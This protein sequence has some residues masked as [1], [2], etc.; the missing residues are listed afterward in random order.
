MADPGTARGTGWRQAAGFPPGGAMPEVGVIG[1]IN[2]DTIHHPDGRS[3]ESLGGILFTACALAHLGQGRLRTRPFARLPREIEPRVEALLGACPEVS[4]GGLRRLDGP[5]FRCEIR[6]DRAGRKSERLRGD[7]PPLAPPDLPCSNSSLDALLVNFITGFELEPDTLRG[8][9]RIVD[10]PILMDVHSLT[11]A[12]DAEG[13]RHPRPPPSWPLWAS[14]A[15][16]VQMNE[17]E[18]RTLG[19]P[20]EELQEWAVSLLDLGP[21]VAVITLGERGALCAWRASDGGV[22]RLRRPAQAVPEGLPVDPTGCGDVFLAAM[23]AG[24]LAGG[25]VPQALDRAIRAASR[26]CTLTGIES[27][28]LLAEEEGP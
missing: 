27:L 17:L 6:Y 10:G 24:L 7:V 13:R 8:L 25:T 12:R 18:A 1:S 16:L 3:S 9:R 11:L 14:M 20:A 23:A 2:L 19:A 26:N 28:G 21:K 5:G 4:L 22:R 15:D